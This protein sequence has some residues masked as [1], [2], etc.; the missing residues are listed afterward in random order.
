MERKRN[1]IFQ[2][3]RNTKSEKIPPPP[4]PQTG[5]PSIMVL[6]R[7][8]NLQDI[9]TGSIFLR[10]TEGNPRNQSWNAFE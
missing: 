5:R 1:E 6:D 2:E 10:H 4:R 8:S 3:E 7:F 9:E